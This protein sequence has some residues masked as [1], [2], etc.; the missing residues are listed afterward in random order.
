[1]KSHGWFWQVVRKILLAL[2]NPTGTVRI[3]FAFDGMRPP[4]LIRETDWADSC[5]KQVSP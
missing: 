2:S 1:M 5:E 3:L 4:D